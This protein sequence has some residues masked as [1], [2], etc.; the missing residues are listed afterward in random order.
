MKDV[1]RCCVQRM[2]R[3]TSRRLVL[4]PARTGLSQT[5]TYQKRQLPMNPELIPEEQHVWVARRRV[6]L[7]LL[8]W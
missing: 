8:Y 2:D 5:S 4:D 1:E 7:D 3:R 6:S